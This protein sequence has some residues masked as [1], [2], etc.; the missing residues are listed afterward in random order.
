MLIL[1]SASND[2]M[3]GQKRKISETSLID[4]A[5]QQASSN[6]MAPGSSPRRP[7]QRKLEPRE[8]PRSAEHE[9]GSQDEEV[10]Q[11]QRDGT[12]NN[13]SVDTSGDQEQKNGQVQIRKT[14]RSSPPKGKLEWHH[15]RQYYCKPDSQTL[16][17]AVTHDSIRAE[18]IASK[19]PEEGQ[20]FVHKPTRGL[21]PH[22]ETS[23][24]PSQK[25]WGPERDDRPDILFEFDPP[26][27]ATKAKRS[28][29]KPGWMMFEGKI[30]LDHHDMPIVDWPGLNATLSASVEPFRLE[31]LFR[32]F[33]KR[34]KGFKQED[35]RA[36]SKSFFS[37]SGWTKNVTS[38][39]FQVCPERDRGF[40]VA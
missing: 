2:T 15:G 5:P 37:D 18:L 14:R 17:E 34:Y 16:H 28:S 21:G 6:T 24:E 27:S 12:S 32:T 10:E 23:F 20:G 38:C 36:R 19:E 33:T 39:R 30:V 22:D 4:T 3:A 13:T 8:D 35:L 7:K 1:K 40:V 9:G 25:R 29:T 31:A 26:N 11:E